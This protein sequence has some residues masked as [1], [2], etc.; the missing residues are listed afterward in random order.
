[1]LQAV[2]GLPDFAKPVIGPAT[3]GR[4][5]WLIRATALNTSRLAHPH[6]PWS[7]KP[8]GHCGRRQPQKADA[9]S[10]SAPSVFFAGSKKV[11]ECALVQ[12]HGFCHG[13]HRTVLLSYF[14]GQKRARPKPVLRQSGMETGEGFATGKRRAGGQPP[15]ARARRSAADKQPGAAGWGSTAGRHEGCLQK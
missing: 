7:T 13:L 12:L 8:A 6:N 1:M 4:T 14:G 10:L 15:R 9:K 3:S 11:D 2:I 5:R